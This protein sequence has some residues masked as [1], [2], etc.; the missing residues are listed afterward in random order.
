MGSANGAIIA[1]SKARAQQGEQDG[2]RV[3]TVLPVA[4]RT[5]RKNNIIAKESKKAA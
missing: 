4:V 5:Q 3:N 2:V 1:A